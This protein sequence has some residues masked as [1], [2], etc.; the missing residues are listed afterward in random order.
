VAIGDHMAAGERL[1][2]PGM[3]PRGP[4]RVVHEADAHPL[5]FDDEPPRQGRAQSLLVHVPVHRRHRS[6]RPEVVEDRASGEVAGVQ[7]EIC[8]LEN[9]D[10]TSGQ[11]ARAA[12]EVRISEKG[13]QLRSDRNS[14]LR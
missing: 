6:E 8:L 2:E 10:T 9:A 11:A 4:A 5:G 3:P 7:D 1:E 12:R 13:D 14:P